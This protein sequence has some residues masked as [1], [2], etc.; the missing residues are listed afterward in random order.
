M[1]LGLPTVWQRMD[2]GEKRSRIQSSSECTSFQ[3][4]RFS[5]LSQDILERHLLL[6][7]HMQDHAAWACCCRDLDRAY[8][9][10]LQRRPPSRGFLP[11]THFTFPVWIFTLPS[12]HPLFV[13][14]LSH[15]TRLKAIHI[16]DETLPQLASARARSASTVDE[17]MR[18]A[19]DELA[20]QLW[21]GWQVREPCLSLPRLPASCTR[22]LLNDLEAYRIRWSSLVDA[23]R[24]CHRT[25]QRISIEARSL[26]LSLDDVMLPSHVPE[27]CLF[28]CVKSLRLPVLDHPLSSACGTPKIY[29]FS[30]ALSW[31]CL[32]F[33]ALTELRIMEPSPSERT[34]LSSCW[35][36]LSLIVDTPHTHLEMMRHNFREDRFILPQQLERIHFCNSLVICPP[37]EDARRPPGLRVFEVGLVARLVCVICFCTTAALPLRSQYSRDAVA[38]HAAAVYEA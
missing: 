8:S 3:A 6:F 21:R 34:D 20:I 4:G 7:M 2:G 11:F 31:M 15:L 28:P 26:D 1:S 35:S 29:C 16:V 25:I 33:S 22:L 9:L 14:D 19:R 27:A 17:K 32:Q 5:N 38:K 24:S 36:L 12:A 23:S 18:N 13:D 10:S 37:P 30:T